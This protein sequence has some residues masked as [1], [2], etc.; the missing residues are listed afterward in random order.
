MKRYRGWHKA[1]KDRALKFFLEIWAILFSKSYVKYV[2]KKTYGRRLNLKKP[3]DYNE[4]IQ[5]LKIYSDISLWTDLADKYRVREYVEG[6]GLGDILVKL[7]GVWKDAKNIDF[8]ILPD[9]FV[10]KTNHGFGKIIIV[11]DK[12]ALDKDYVVRLLNSWVKER[13]G[14]LSFE[15]HYWNIQRRIIAEELLVD[16]SMEGHS[17]SLIDYKLFCINGEPQV[18]KVMYNREILRDGE[19]LKTNART[20]KTFTVDLD[21][22]LRPDLVPANFSKD[23][24]LTLPKPKC[25]SEMISV[26]RILSKPFPQVRVDLYEVKNKVYFGELTFTPG[27]KY[28]FTPEYLKYLGNRMDL[29]N[30]KLRKRWF[31]V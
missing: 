29:A 28:N 2:Y 1:Y 13:Y 30:V 18:I 21:W 3:E 25:L 6:R 26:A 7:Y 12:K 23:W 16:D 8:D 24:T 19:D 9:K 27:G 11:N 15:P 20:F 14:L 5:W 31:I 22:K 17:N 10:L 4:K